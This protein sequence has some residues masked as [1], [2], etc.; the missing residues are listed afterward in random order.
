[1][2]TRWLVWLL[3]WLQQWCARSLERLQRRRGDRAVTRPWPRRSTPPPHWLEV[4]RARAPRL[5][6][7]DATEFSYAWPAPTSA[8]A[9]V[10]RQ[11]RPPRTATAPTTEPRT[12]VSSQPRP[13]RT[14]A[15]AATAEP[16]APQE[17]ARPSYSL[18]LRWAVTLRRPIS[19]SSVRAARE[20]DGA[21]LTGGERPASAAAAEARSHDDRDGRRHAT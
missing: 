11:A 10:S 8:H 5:L 6:D 2:L 18:P 1:M 4:V 3:E 12:P 15:A 21:I 17:R 13:L 7:P 9:P 20:R 19:S 16:R 14:A